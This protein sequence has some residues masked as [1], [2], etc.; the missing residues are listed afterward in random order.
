M[1]HRIL[2]LLV[3]GCCCLAAAEGQRQAE[4]NATQVLPLA[5]YESLNLASQVVQS[6]SAGIAVQNDN[7][8][9][10]AMLNGSTFDEPLSN[11]SAANLY[12]LDTL[13]DAHIGRHQVI[14]SLQSEADQ[15]FAFHWQDVQLGLAYGYEIVAQPNVSVV[16]GGG[17]AYGDFGLET[18]AG[19]NW[20]L[21][22]IPLLR[23]NY[24][25]NIADAKFEFLTTPNLTVTLAPNSP[26]RFSGDVRFD[27]LRSARDIIFEA[28]LHYRFFTPDHAYGDFAGVAIGLKNDHFSSYSLMDD[29]APAELQYMAAFVSLDATLVKVTTG[30]AFANRIYQEEK[31]EQAF[32]DGFYVSVQGMLAF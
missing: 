15:P 6:I 18:S 12:T 8:L 11:T 14:A 4:Q 3:S 20:P 24:R 1:M 29:V 7:L 30:Y 13:V 17:L 2:T 22:P 10:V 25:S 21:L 26:L 27:Q 5:Q 31:D 19:K 9:M 32:G 16:A 28:A 23:V